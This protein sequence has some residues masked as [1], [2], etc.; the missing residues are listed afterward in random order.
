M[1]Y[2]WKLI[3]LTQRVSKLY[4]MMRLGSSLSER[5]LFTHHSSAHRSYEIKSYS[6]TNTVIMRSK[7]GIQVWLFSCCQHTMQT[8]STSSKATE[9]I[10]LALTTKLFNL[11]AKKV[12]VRKAGRGQWSSRG[13]PPLTGGTAP[14]VKWQISGKQLRMDSNKKQHTREL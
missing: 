8:A 9:E 12:S 4:S 7:R 1:Q 13:W 5:G 10:S 14:E 6:V 3:V 11:H 2:L